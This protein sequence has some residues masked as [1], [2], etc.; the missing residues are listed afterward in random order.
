M[1]LAPR[2]AC[3]ALKMVV[4]SSNATFS[5]APFLSLMW[6]GL[7]WNPNHHSTS[8]AAATT[9]AAVK[10]LMTNFK[11]CCCRNFFF[12][13]NVSARKFADFFS[14]RVS[15]RV[16]F[17]SVSEVGENF[18]PIQSRWQGWIESQQFNTSQS[19]K[20][21]LTMSRCRIWG[22]FPGYTQL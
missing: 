10:K 13:G 15:V 2:I 14:R 18:G 21:V 22:S 12:S 20:E 19:F 8:R 3:L 9:A 16:R 5:S 1:S 11:S 17:F 7:C 6:N 4:M